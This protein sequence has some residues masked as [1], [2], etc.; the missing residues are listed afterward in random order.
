MHL[1]MPAFAACIAMSA[2]AGNAAAQQSVI[3][4]VV[5]SLTSR[6]LPAASVQLLPT[7][8]G[9]VSHAD[10]RFVLPGIAP[11]VYTLV[12]DLIGYRQATREVRVDPGTTLNLRVALSVSAVAMGAIVVTGTVAPR[13]RQDVI[14]PVSVLSAAELDRRAA[15]TV[16]AMLESKPGIAVTSLGP[17]TARPVIRGLSG[18]RIV[19]LEDGQRPGDMSSTGADH[20]VGVQPLT[21]QRIEIV[22]GPM[23]LLYGSSALG[24]VV[25]VIRNEIPTSLPHELQ[26]VVSLRTASG[27]RSV[28][29]GAFGVAALG[30]FAVR[31]EASVLEA[32]DLRTPRGSITGTDART[33]DVSISAARP[34]EHGHGGAS[35][36]FYSNDYGVPGGFVGGHAT[37]VS[38]AMRRH[39]VRIASELHRDDRRWTRFRFDGGYTNYYHAE[40][41]PSGSLGTAFGQDLVQGEMVARHGGRG[42]VTEGAAGMRA[43]YRDIRTGGSL[44]TPSTYDVALAGFAIEELG[45]G[46]LHVQMGLRYDY[47]HYVPRDTASFVTAGGV[48]IPVRARSFGAVSGSVGALVAATPSLRLGASVSRAY[49]T[50]DF[51]ELYSN[52]PHLAANSFDVGDPTLGQETGLG[53]DAFVR[54]SSELV[55]A[56]IAAYR[57][58]L[59][60]FIF[61]S[62]RGRAELGA[63]GGRPRFQYTNENARFV[64]IEGELEATLPRN[65]YLEMSGSIV[66][67]DFTSF[68]ASIPVFDGVDTTFITA[69]TYPP[70]IPPAQGR[71]GMRIDRP[72]RFAG[73]GVKLVARQGRIGDFETATNGYALIDMTMGLR[74]T[75]RGLLHTITVRCDN[76]MNT[77]FQDHLSRLKD[78]M[79]G[80]GR[81]ASLLYRVVF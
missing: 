68:R 3:G 33:Y 54:W 24:G 10:G 17:S 50:P 5:D 11:G 57:N 19:V 13:A 60:D 2:H 78:I 48:R 14:S 55:N 41:E 37:A 15:T 27:N 51:N 29:G 42:I 22:R 39:S 64:G 49:R 12:V 47:A 58:T 77:E 56:E 1:Y 63:Q 74:I 69:S 16:A 80:A 53:L 38:I 43:S 70:L 76:V 81:S 32:G 59:D 4:I 25:N 62:S 67:A 46:K 26:G 75:R 73:A 28:N 21:A 52:G 20:A 30:S 40:T 65:L 66:N 7:H 18:D 34:A 44:K 45:R 71:M 72:S 79:P 61:P 23:S 31:A 9:D 35:Y 8:V 36:R 6:P